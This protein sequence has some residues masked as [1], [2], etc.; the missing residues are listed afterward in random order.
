MPAMKNI[1]TMT[2]DTSDGKDVTDTSQIKGEAKKSSTWN[3]KNETKQH[4]TS[5]G[6]PKNNLGGVDSAS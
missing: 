5:G 4:Y 2:I 1:R 3:E 6:V